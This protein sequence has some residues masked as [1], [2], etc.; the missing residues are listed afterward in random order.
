MSNEVFIAKVR[1]FFVHALYAMGWLIFSLFYV[2]LLPAVW[3]I[4][5][6]FCRMIMMH[7]KSTASMK[8]LKFEHSKMVVSGEG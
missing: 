2:C 8:T 6:G 5:V 7:S 1:S 4:I 3:K